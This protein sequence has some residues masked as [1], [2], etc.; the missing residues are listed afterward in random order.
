MKNIINK[1]R[2]R[3]REKF[4][5]G[6]FARNVLIMFTGTAL[7]QLTSLLLSP[8]L[9]RI[10]SPEMFGI[11]GF[12]TSL[13]GILGVV[14]SL[15]YD[16]ALPI[17]KS[18]EDAANLLAVCF[19][20]LFFV[21]SVLYG[22]LLFTPDNSV[23]YALGSL[24]PYRHLL[25]VGFLCIGAYQIMV[26]YA[27]QREAF[28]VLAKTKIYQ[29]VTGPVSQIGLGLMGAGA[30]GL[31]IGFIL[32]HSA[33][34]FS[35]LSRLVLKPRDVL[36]NISRKGMLAIAK[37]FSNFPLISTWSSMISVLGT[38]T[39]M[40][41]VVPIIYSNTVAGFIFLTERIIGRPLLLISTS[42]LQVYLGEAAKT[43]TS[44]PRAM[45]RRFLQITKG[46]FIIVSAW[47]ALINATAFYLVPIVFGKQWA[48]AVIY[49]NILSICY[50]P[51][52]VIVAVQHT[53]QIMEK[54][55][56]TAIWEFGR[57]VLITGGFLFSY[58][59]K[60]EP[61]QGILIYSVSQAFA[62]IVL[63]WFMYSSIQKLQPKEV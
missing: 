18:K 42:I 46:Q 14:A 61:E 37:R 60:L 34:F 62:Q 16:M 19:F 53:L 45:R 50:L 51:Q 30:W 59:Y 55:L 11:V 44:D 22:C 10:Y 56:L 29:G 26:G 48:G 38:N 52:M 58:V 24:Y 31:I 17:A 41:L 4:T 13:L 40:S 36:P 47:L 25:P 15:R 12:F 27:T 21:T 23:S 54:Q 8:A 7:G 1:V 5:H 57:F 9:T 6:S 63:F 33:G 39:M 20:T 32:G 35:M 28:A 3:L 49:I 43:Q 2:A